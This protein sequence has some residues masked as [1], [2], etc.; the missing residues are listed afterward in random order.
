MAWLRISGV[1]AFGIAAGLTVTACGS[2]PGSAAPASAAGSKPLSLTT[3]TVAGYE[4]SVNW[5]SL[6]AAQAEGFYAKQGLTVKFVNTTASAASMVAATIGDSYQ[7]IA[8]DPVG[9]PAAVQNGAQIRAVLTPDVGPTDD[10]VVSAKAAAEHHLPASGTLA[11]LRA[12]KGSHLT[13]G[14][15]SLTAGSYLDLLAVFKAQGLTASTGSGSDIKVVSVGS[16]N[17]EADGLASGHLDGFVNM[18][19]NTEVPDAVHV[20][21]GGVAPVSMEPPLAFTTSES[22]IESHPDTVQAFVTATVE[23]WEYTRQHPS[24][25]KQID[26]RVFPTVGVTDAAKIGELYQLDQQHRGSTPAITGAEYQAIQDVLQ[27]AGTPTTVSYG[28]FVDSSFV[29]QAITQLKLG[30]PT[31]S[32]AG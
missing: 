9:L 29:N 26:S 11:Q 6:W 32:A 24:Q 5:A 10:L 17:D 27:A 16:L 12:L 21:F 19:P 28:G 25:T 31:G 18:Y 15:V 13:I 4:G 2:G 1:I 20:M 14:V 7:F 8:A 23:G 3:V 22:M 30:L